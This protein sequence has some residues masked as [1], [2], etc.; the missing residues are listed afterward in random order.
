MKENA[1]FY[2]NMRGVEIGGK[3]GLTRIWVMTARIVI[4]VA[5]PGPSLLR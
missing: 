3:E 4:N 1:V 5:P 2:T